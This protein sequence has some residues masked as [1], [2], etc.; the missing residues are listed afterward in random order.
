LNGVARRSDN[1][2]PTEEKLKA[3]SEDDPFRH[4]VRILSDLS[5]KADLMY[6]RFGTDMAS[7]GKMCGA[8]KEYRRTRLAWDVT[9]RA[10]EL[11]RV[12]G[13]KI[14]KGDMTSEFSIGGTMKLGWTPFAEASYCDYRDERGRNPFVDMGQHQRVVAAACKL[15]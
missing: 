15:Q 11:S 1:A 9:V 14:F 8:A 4:V 5:A 12:L 2:I 13:F 10:C 6:E 3:Y 7:E